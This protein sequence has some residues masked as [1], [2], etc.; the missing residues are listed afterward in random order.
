M[1]VA[2][3]TFEL[4][5]KP[6]TSKPPLTFEEA[7]F[8]SA[9][10]VFVKTEFEMLDSLAMPPLK[11]VFDALLWLR[12]ALFNSPP[13]T[14]EFA[15]LPPFTTEPLRLDAFAVAFASVLP[16]TFEPLTTPPFTTEPVTL[17]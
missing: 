10:L 8:D 2:F 9:V 15:T 14:L 16:L 1:I 17:L 13:F 7:M 5:T 3:A 12:L 4:S 6:P 11:L